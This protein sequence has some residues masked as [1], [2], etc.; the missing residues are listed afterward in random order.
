MVGR[1]H[2]GGHFGT[3]LPWFLREHVLPLLREEPS[4]EGVR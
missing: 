3:D 1:G 2:L 4:S